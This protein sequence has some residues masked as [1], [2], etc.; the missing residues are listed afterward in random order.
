MQ[1]VYQAY[2]TK[3]RPIVEY[4]TKMLSVQAG[5]RIMEP[6]AGDGVF[7]DSIIGSIADVQ[8]DAYDLNPAAIDTL[9][10]KFS[11]KE[12]IYIKHSDTIIDEELTFFTQMG[13]IYDRIIGNPPY[14]AWQDYDKR[15]YLKKLYPEIYVK[16]TYASFLFRCVNL[17]VEDGRLVFIIPDTFLN[18]H[19]HTGLRRFLLTNTKIREIALFPS[20]FF[21]NVNFGYSNLSII[22]L[23]KS[24]SKDDCLNNT[25]MILSGFENAEELKEPEKCGRKIVFS[26]KEIYA[27]PDHA[28]FSST[29]A[30]ISLINSC[31]L[32]IGDIANC[33]TGIYS[34]ND[35][36]YIRPVSPEIKNSKKY[37]LLDKE[38]IATDFIYESSLLHGI[39][40][41]KCFIPI[42]KGGAVKYLKPDN[43]YI[44]WSLGAVQDYKMNK[45]AR[46]QN[47]SY[48]FKRG[49][50]VP[51]VSSTQVTASLME[52][53]V[54]DQSIVGVFPHDPSLIHYLL[55]FFNSPTC[56]KLLRAINPSANNSANYIKK[57][58]FISPTREIK[59]IITFKT[60]ELIEGLKG[61]DTYN[62]EYETKIN[63]MIETLYGL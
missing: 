60:N 53:K 32:K 21:P 42:V 15:K 35:T 22:T 8:L 55:A 63:Q 2:Y 33:V 51:M 48:Y 24:S 9:Y 6:S 54:F 45:K 27:H 12:N 52:G 3:S 28:F 43:W 59:D 19:M 5:M 14:G 61:N 40:D 31:E 56:T 37:L 10:K 41:I 18:L 46:F 16:E 36:K 58:P 11:C 7:I 29:G 44:D 57:I 30:V 47:S 62:Y 38:L 1:D 4:M 23:E 49:I 26:Q 50:G 39:N 25:C 20:S 17:L 13:G 34:G